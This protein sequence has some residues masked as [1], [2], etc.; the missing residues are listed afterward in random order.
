MHSFALTKNAIIL[1]EFPLTVNP[2]DLL[3]NK[4]GFINNFVW[5][6]EHGTN[7]IV[8]DRITG[9]FTNINYP[10]PFFAFHHV[11]AFEKGENIILDIVTYPDAQ[12][13]SNIAV[14]GD[15]KPDVVQEKKIDGN[16]KRT[17]L[18]RYTLSL[19]EKSIKS[20]VLLEKQ[21]E[22]PR[23]NENYNTHEHR[24]IY[25][26]D[27]R[28]S[29]GAKD[30]RHLYK[31]DTKT[32]QI[33]K[34]AEPGLMPGEPVFIAHPAK[35]DEDEGVIVTIVLD[36]NK[37]NAFLLMLDAKTFKEI[38]RCYAPYPIPAGLHGQFFE[39]Q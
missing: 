24:Y 13:I 7:F 14:H 23:I 18:I 11:N 35:T 1:V 32:D 31:I 8:I 6:P 28:T 37:Q 33:A 15:L 21:I 9:K 12:I 2:L 4:K 25:L 26:V 22:F 38:A 39:R 29:F 17:K 20:K 34:W 3:L 10:K 5:H 16:L 30:I 19:N 36:N 27:P